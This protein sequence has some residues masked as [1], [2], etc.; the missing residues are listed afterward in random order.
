MLATV[1]FSSSF[2]TNA[3][4]FIWFYAILLGSAFGFLYLPALRNAW[5]YFP[6]KKGLLSGLIIS[7]QPAGGILWI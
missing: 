4:F 2:I 5:Q 3:S 6:K 7:C 1:N